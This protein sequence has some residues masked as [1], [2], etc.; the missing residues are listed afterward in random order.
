MGFEASC[1][2]ASHQA[3]P[4]DPFDTDALASHSMNTVAP[5]RRARSKAARR[6][7]VT[8]SAIGSPG[9]FR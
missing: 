9:R 8:S 4:T 5:S 3:T 7:E 6:T 1:R 2:I